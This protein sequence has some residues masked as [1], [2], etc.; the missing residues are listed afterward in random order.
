MPA[1]ARDTALVVARI[2]LGVV[3]IAHGA[4]KFFTNGIDGTATGFASMEI[5]LPTLSAFVAAT[6]ELVG[7]ALLILGLATAIAGLL[8]VLNMLMA[9]LLVHVGNGI[10]VTDGG[11]ELV[12]VIAALA[13]TLAAVGPGR[14]SVDHAVSARRRPLHSH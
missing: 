13:L 14:F 4:Q 6:I 11:W 2:V 10:F 9:A 8:V 5:P 3:L 12:G 1:S 7:G